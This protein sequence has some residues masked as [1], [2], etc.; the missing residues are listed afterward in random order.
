MNDAVLE[1]RAYYQ[2]TADAY[3][4][5]H[6]DSDAEHAVALSA[7]VGLCALDPP[8]RILDV[9]AGTGRA[10]TV[11]Q[12]RLPGV[13]IVGIEPV[14]ALREIG[15]ENGIARDCLV[16]GDVLAM[17]FADNAF[18]YVI[19]T[20]VLHHVPDPARALAEMVRVASKGVMLS[21]SNKFGQGSPIARKLKAL[22]DRVGLWDTLI[23]FQ[24][25][26]KMYKYSESDG[27]YYSYSVFDHLDRVE[28]KFPHIMMMN[29]TRSTGF[30][31]R[32]GASHAMIFATAAP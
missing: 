28:R 26:G 4:A 29:T 22:I 20:G 24:T 21:D 30:D 27:V 12:Q 7:F 1:Q 8:S 32:A 6:L 25:K 23:R 16:D 31:L 19:E 5:L 11:L 14:A 13:E 10:I 9:G 2:R 15:F 17:P 3:N 18:D